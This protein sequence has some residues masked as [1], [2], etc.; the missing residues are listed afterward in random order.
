MVKKGWRCALALMLCLGGWQTGQ[1]WAAADQSSSSSELEQKAGSDESDALETSV[2]LRWWNPTVSG[3][4]GGDDYFSDRTQEHR[5]DF[6]QDLGTDHMTAA[7]EVR[8]RHGKWYLDYLRLSSD[9]RDYDLPDTI[10]HGS[11]IYS[12]KLDTEMTMNYVALD[13]RQDMEKTDKRQYYWTVGA[14]YLDISATS[15]GLN[16]KNQKESDSDSARGVVPSVGI[17]AKWASTTASK[18]QGS[19]Y[20]SGMPLGGYGH[21]ADF[22]AVVDYRPAAEWQVSAGYRVLDMDL[23]RSDKEVAIKARGPFLGVS[24]YF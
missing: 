16:T 7:P 8:L 5:L 14:K 17:G 22:E 2:E 10:V 19:V 23:H 4:I 20:L 24:Y 6:E 18:W 21:I 15:R 11:H 13:Y 1:A 3:S 12:G 9:V